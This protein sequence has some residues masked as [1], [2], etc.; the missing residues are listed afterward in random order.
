VIG[1]AK[2]ALDRP[3]PSVQARLEAGDG[4]VVGQTTT[5]EQ[6]RFSFADVAPGT[7]VVVAAKD[8]FETATAVVTVSEGGDA[9]AAL[10]LASRTPLDV[11]VAAK[12]LEE[13]RI[14]SQPRIGAATHEVRKTA[15][16]TPARAE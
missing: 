6:G 5:D 4:R 16:E 9:S 1:I 7:Y 15:V 10:T 14:Q 2:D 8:G 11:A 12:R 3:L 13:A